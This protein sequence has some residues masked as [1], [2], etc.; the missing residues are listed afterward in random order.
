M[1]YITRKEQ[2]IFSFTH[3]TTS[4]N[5]YIRTNYRSWFNS[6]FFRNPTWTMPG[7]IS[8]T[9]IQRGI[10]STSEPKIVRLS[11][12]NFQINICK[13]MNNERRTVISRIICTHKQWMNCIYDILKNLKSILANLKLT[14]LI[15]FFFFLFFFGHIVHNF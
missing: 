9:L 7:V 10:R 8:F 1:K 12:L 6:S 4:V 3:F 2:N 14:C 15:F 5:L 11:M 13:R